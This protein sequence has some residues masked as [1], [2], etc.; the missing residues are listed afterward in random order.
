MNRKYIK[1]FLGAGFTLTEILLVV[2]I[3]GVVAG[4]GLPNFTKMFRRADEKDAVAQLKAV[5]AAQELYA[6]RNNQQYAAAADTAAVNSDLNLSIMG[7]DFR[8]SCTTSNGGLDYSCQALHNDE[9]Y[10]VLIGN[11]DIDDGNPCCDTATGESCP[12]LADCS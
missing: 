2:V 5:H 9:G 6:A 4:W 10:A 7:Q 11:G 8:Y 1:I 12:T 3:L